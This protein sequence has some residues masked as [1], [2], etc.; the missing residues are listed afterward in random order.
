MPEFWDDQL[1]DVALDAEVCG[2]V[3]TGCARQ[4]SGR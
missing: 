3:Y 1:N 4:I 2:P